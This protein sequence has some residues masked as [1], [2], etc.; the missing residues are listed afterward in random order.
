[1]NQ[2]GTRIGPG[3]DAAGWVPSHLIAE[4][5]IPENADDAIFTGFLS[6]F[7]AFLPGV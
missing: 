1:M 4:S 7:I 2:E 3:L 6:F 5:E